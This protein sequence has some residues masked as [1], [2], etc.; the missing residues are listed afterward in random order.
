VYLHLEG[1]S[2]A[3][4]PPLAEGL[5]ELLAY[6]WLTEAP[7]ATAPHTARPVDDA[8]RRARVE[9]MLR[10][11]DRVYGLGFRE[12]LA[13]F[14][15]VDSSL[16]RL[17]AEVKQRGALPHATG[18]SMSGRHRA[19]PGGARGANLPAGTRAFAGFGRA[20]AKPMG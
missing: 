1:F 8:E 19:G 6:L 18:P 3:L 14:Y 12:A 20:V 16:T 10:S 2:T 4:P 13:A 7:K 9:G 5:C 17:F 15:A 11:S